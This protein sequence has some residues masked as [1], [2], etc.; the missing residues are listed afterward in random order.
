VVATSIIMQS[1]CRVATSRIRSLSFWSRSPP[2]YTEFSLVSPV[3]STAYTPGTIPR[4]IPRP[5]YA[6]TGLT[7]PTLIP[8]TPVLWSQLEID[9]IRRSCQLARKVLNSLHDIIEPGIPTEDIDAHARDMITL[10]NA[11][12]SPLNFQ[13]FPKS[14]STSVNNVAAHG[15]PDSRPLESGDILNIDVTVYLDG[16]HGDCSDTFKV[17]QVDKH[18]DN[19]I[20]VTRECL[21]EGIKACGPGKWWRGIGHAVQKHAKKNRCTTIPLF[22]G[23]GIGDF[24]H[25]PP[26]IYH[27]LNNYPGQMKPGMVFTVEPVVSEGDRRVKILED[28]WTAITL[29]NSRTAQMEHTILVTEEGVEILT[30][31][32]HNEALS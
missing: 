15:I 3:P 10:H 17:G 29:D 26:D 16:Y 7:D 13:G 24:F 4:H 32:N 1:Y 22:L 19:L 2:P 25:G 12:P 5:P 8:N 14:I 6:L 9:K 27:C 31:D 11:Y 30:A 18:A 28:G 21:E 23:H 20:N